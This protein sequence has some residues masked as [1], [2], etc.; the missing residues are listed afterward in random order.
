MH[1]GM[2]KSQKVLISETSLNLR[3]FI[4][5]AAKPEQKNSNV[6]LGR[7]FKYYVSSGKLC[8]EQKNGVCPFVG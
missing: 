3:F 6:R 5:K 4:I 7:S 8:L 2:T 1:S